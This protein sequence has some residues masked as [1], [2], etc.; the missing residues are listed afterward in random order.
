MEAA[1]IGIV[2]ADAAIAALVSTRVNWVER[3]QGE[4]LPAI[5]LGR[6]GG[7]RDYHTQGASGL[8]ESRIQG[9]CYATTYAGAKSV[10]RALIALLSGYR[11][12]TGDIEFKGAFVDG[13]RDFREADPNGSE[14]LHRVSVDFII[15]HSE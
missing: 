6:I 5:V 15:H 9:D 2:L 4:P 10:A 1:L 11:G 7:S 12:T 3:P 8:V 14:K 13:E